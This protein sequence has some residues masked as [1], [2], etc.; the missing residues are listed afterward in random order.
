MLEQA[1]PADVLAEQAPTSG[2][3]GGHRMWVFVAD[4]LTPRIAGTAANPGVPSYREN[5]RSTRARVKWSGSIS[6]SAAGSVHHAPAPRGGA[7]GSD[8]HLDPTDAQ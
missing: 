3:G 8:R 2:A 1:P 6:L 4:Q 5:R 7:R